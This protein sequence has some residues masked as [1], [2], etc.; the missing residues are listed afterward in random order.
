M[1]RWRRSS[2]SQTGSPNAE[3]AGGRVKR[4][5]RGEKEQKEEAAPKLQ[6]RAGQSE[7]RGPN[8]AR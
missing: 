7:A 3:T 6:V 5:G 4:Y 2:Q 1:R 8:V